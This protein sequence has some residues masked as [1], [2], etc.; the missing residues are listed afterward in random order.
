M[1]AF[2]L[3]GEEEGG[4]T[5]TNKN[6][7]NEVVQHQEPVADLLLILPINIIVIMT[8]LFISFKLLSNLVDIR[9]L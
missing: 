8:K 2:V 7:H 1:L 4:N 3:L 9:F 6:K 5:Y